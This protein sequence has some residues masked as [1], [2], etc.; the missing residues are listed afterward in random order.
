MITDWRSV[1]KAILKK[2]QN[3]LARIKMIKYKK[4][5]NT[6]GARNKTRLCGSASRKKQFK[7]F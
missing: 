5:K 2:C 1:Y 3:L 7:I 6:M 4:H